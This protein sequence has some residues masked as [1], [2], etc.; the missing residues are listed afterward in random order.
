M[1]LLSFFI[2]DIFGQWIN[3]PYW[4]VGLKGGGTVS[5]VEYTLRDYDV[6]SHKP[7]KDYLAGAFVKWRPMQRLGLMIDFQYLGGGV[8]L[9][10]ADVDYTLRSKHFDTRF[11]LALHLADRDKSFSPYLAGGPFISFPMGGEIEY[12]SDYTPY[13][14]TTITSGDYANKEYGAYVC[15]GF[16]LQFEVGNSVMMASLE[17]GIRWGLSSTFAE[18][19]K[20]QNSTVLNPEFDAPFY[21]EERLNRSAEIALR[22]GV[23]LKK[24]APQ[25]PRNFDYYFP[26]EETE[27]DSVEEKRPVRD[28]E[29]KQCYSI[30]EIRDKINNGEDVRGL[31]ICLFNVLFDFDRWD[32]RP[33]SEFMI[34]DLSALLRRYPELRIKVSG[35]TDSR[36]SD[37]Y[38]QALS[39][40]RAKSVKYAIMRYGVL[41]ERITWEGFGESRPIDT[42]DTDEGRARNRRV[43]IDFVE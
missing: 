37:E 3:T 34:S 8:N 39:E 24:K 40:R 18:G 32:I 4:V 26:E 14:V 28:Y 16:D 42:N 15:L 9:K 19:D 2:G 25:T 12:V 27:E 13:F 11:L 41:G 7:Q 1:S 43:E 21:S 29:P 23:P 6:Y 36:G 38:N 5:D 22:L 30:G 33:E 20:D 35:H 31:R 10:W 17:A